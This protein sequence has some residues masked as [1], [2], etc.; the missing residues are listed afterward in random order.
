MGLFSRSKKYQ[1]VYEEEE[2]ATPV[3]EPVESASISL[4]GGDI[5]LKMV[6]PSSFEQLLTAV[7]FLRDGK[8]VLVNLEDADEAIFSRM[9]DFMSG[10]AFALNANIKQATSDSYIL[11][12]ADVNVGG[13]IF[14]KNDEE[15]LSDL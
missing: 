4:G 7:D 10:A 12:P 1:E 14:K 13:G 15:T 8:T 11:T 2:V 6:K 5:Q 3:E 9:I